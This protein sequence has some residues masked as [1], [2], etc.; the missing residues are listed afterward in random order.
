MCKGFSDV[1]KVLNII[2]SLN[3]SNNAEVLFHRDLKMLYPPALM[4]GQ[5]FYIQM[6]LLFVCMFILS[7]WRFIMYLNYLNVILR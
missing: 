1:F 7:L 3:N 6:I 2:L 5:S 4:S